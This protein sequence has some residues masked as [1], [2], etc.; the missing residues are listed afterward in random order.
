MSWRRNFWLRKPSPSLKGRKRSGRRN[1]VNSGVRLGELLEERLCLSGGTVTLSDNTMQRIPI[2]VYG[3][4]NIATVHAGQ[5]VDITVSTSSK[6]DTGES[7]EV[8]SGTNAPAAVYI[9]VN[10]EKV[11]GPLKDW[12]YSYDVPYTAVGDNPVITA[13]IVGADGDETAVVNANLKP[14]SGYTQTQR[15]MLGGL[16]LLTTVAGTAVNIAGYGDPEPGTKLVLFGLGTAI[17]L[18][19]VKLGAMALDPPDPN[20]QVADQAQT[21]QL[22]SFTAGGDVTQQIANA[23]NSL[24]TNLTTT[25]GLEQA[26]Y[27]AEN[28]LTGAEQAG[29]SQWTTYHQQYIAYAN[30]QLAP[31]LSAEPGLFAALQ[32]AFQ[33]AGVSTNVTA[34]QITSVEQDILSNG[35]P[36]G[37]SDILTQLGAT[38]NEVDQITGMMASQDPTSTAGDAMAQLTGSDATDSLTSVAASLGPAQSLPTN[39][40]QVAAY[41]T[42]GAEYYTN[43]IDAAYQK[44]LGRPADSDGLAYWLPLMQQG[45][46]SDE[47]LESGFIGSAEYIANHGGQGAGWV[48]GMYNDLLGRPPDQAGLNYWVNQL[49]AGANPNDVAYGFAASQERESQRI[50]QDYLIYLGRP[51]DAAGQQYWVNQ[52]LNGYPNESVIAGFIGSAEYY[53]K[54]NKGDSHIVDWV[55]SMFQDALGRQPTPSELSYYSA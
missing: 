44:Y 12:N 55:D 25:I 28:R 3:S 17:T 4:N 32:S 39:L 14:S 43:I 16:S 19:G 23:G 29:D 53:Q 31:L 52:F 8:E 30:G 46:V 22:S 51:L 10:G 47:R 36:Q 50:G 27:T 13:Q 7:G 6:S 48:S 49:A 1:N 2:V 26:I 21:P 38:S 41:I 24:L 45:T 18:A 15:Y 35:L 11:N 54:A 9:Y 34:D 20:Y 42:H 37:M 5:V 33:A 40:T